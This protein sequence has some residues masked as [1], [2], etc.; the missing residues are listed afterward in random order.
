MS[1]NIELRFSKNEKSQAIAIN[2]F[3]SL[4]KFFVG[5][6]RKKQRGIRGKA[7]DGIH[8]YTRRTH[9]NHRIPFV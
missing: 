5:K 9:A 4:I 8:L 2:V 7:R 3:D 6:I 1:T